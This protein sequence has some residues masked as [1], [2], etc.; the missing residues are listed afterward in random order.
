MDASASTLDEL[1]GPRVLHS[2]CALAIDLQDFI[3]DLRKRKKSRKEGR[4]KKKWEAEM[5][6]DVEWQVK[7]EEVNQREKRDGEGKTRRV[8]RREMGGTKGHRD[9]G[10]GRREE[11]L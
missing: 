5:I 11:Q 8:D 10:T 4:K 7:R 6:D 1:D 2:L 9:K 3:T